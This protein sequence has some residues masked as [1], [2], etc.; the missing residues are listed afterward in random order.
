MTDTEKKNRKKPWVQVTAVGVFWVVAIITIFWISFTNKG[1]Y[2]KVWSRLSTLFTMLYGISFYLYNLIWGKPNKSTT[3]KIGIVVVIVLL[4]AIAI[5][6]AEAFFG[7]YPPG[8]GWY[9]FLDKYSFICLAVYFIV[10]D[11]GLYLYDKVKYQHEG[12]F[13]AFVDLPTFVGFLAIL[14][15]GNYEKLANWPHFSAGANAFQLVA[16]NTAFTVLLISLTIKE[17][18]ARNEN[19]VPESGQVKH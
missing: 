7:V 13:A 12:Y 16:F 4:F 2:E 10:V 19:C 9:T 1:E 6:T 11:C 3:E 18:K 14:V 8:H 15:L 17:S 5:P